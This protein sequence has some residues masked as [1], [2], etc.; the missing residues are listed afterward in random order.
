MVN[1][2]FGKNWLRFIK[3]LDNQRI[4]EAEKDLIAFAG[5]LKGK[6][7]LD[8]GCGSGLSSLAAWKAGAKKIVSVDIDKDSVKCTKI[9][10]SKYAHDADWKIIQA[11]IL[12]PKKIGRSDIVYSWGV[13]HHTGNMYQAFD[14]ITTLVKPKGLLWIAIY[15]K[16]AG[17][18]DINKLWWQVKKFYNQT[19]PLFR[20]IMFLLYGGSFFIYKLLLGENP[21][22]Q[23]AN[24]KQ[25]RGMRWADDVR[26]WLGGFPY[27]FASVDEIVNYFAKLGC[28]CKKVN[29]RGGIACNDYL[30]IKVGN[31]A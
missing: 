19:G 24:Y 21:W 3:H 7:F 9:L 28:Y 22:K 1:F 16:Y 25:N 13:L 18:V 23:I 2:S 5:D 26:D 12:D 6:T 30:F 4:E 11:S 8:I 20:E 15:N 17:P 29:Y 10:K 27:E 14:N 31:I